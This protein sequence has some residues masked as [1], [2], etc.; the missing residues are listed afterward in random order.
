MNRLENAVGLWTPPS[1]KDFTPYTK[2][3]IAHPVDPQALQLELLSG[4]RSVLRIPSTGDVSLLL[5]Y[6]RREG[7]ISSVQDN[8]MEL[9]I[10]QFQ[11][12]RQEGFRVVQG[13]DITKLM[14]DQIKLLAQSPEVPFQWLTMRDPRKLVESMSAIASEDGA[15]RIPEAEKKYA[16]LI[17]QLGMKYSESEKK[18][19][20]EVKTL[21]PQTEEELN[22]APSG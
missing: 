3:D 8:D 2:P 11:G 13:V 20:V 6:K 12:A 14:A 21:P 5:R 4:D 19:V 9:E 1:A 7:F 22:Q 16:A 10:L 17:S 18:F 15:L